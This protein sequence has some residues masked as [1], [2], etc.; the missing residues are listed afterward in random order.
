MSNA[1]SIIEQFGVSYVMLG[2]RKSP[3]ADAVQEL[4]NATPPALTLTQ[5]LPEGG[6]VFTTLKP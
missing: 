1:R 4:S 5:T 6:A 3:A 2:S